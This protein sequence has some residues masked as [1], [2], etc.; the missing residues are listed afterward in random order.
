VP[1]DDLSSPFATATNEFN[2]LCKK[3]K[4]KTKQKKNNQTQLSGEENII[5]AVFVSSNSFSSA[6]FEPIVA[7]DDEPSQNRNERRNSLGVV[8]VRQSTSSSE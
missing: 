8:T 6:R 5:I 4:N 3:K 7:T 2:L 1:H